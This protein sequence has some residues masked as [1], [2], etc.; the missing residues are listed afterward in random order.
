MVNRGFNLEVQRRQPLL[1]VNKY[2]TPRC[3][4]SDRITAFNFSEVAADPIILRST[5]EPRLVGVLQLNRIRRV[6]RGI[7]SLSLTGSVFRG[8]VLI[9]AL[10]G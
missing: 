3:R 8:A 2:K 7:R 10:P 4:G 6:G 1:W 5:A 9:V